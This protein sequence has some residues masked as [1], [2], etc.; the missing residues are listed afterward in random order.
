M[1]FYYFYSP[2]KHQNFGLFADDVEKIYPDICAYDADD[3]L[4]SIYY[5]RLPI[6]LLREVQRLQTEIELLKSK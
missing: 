5:E 3:K 6:M 2:G 1:R 4:M